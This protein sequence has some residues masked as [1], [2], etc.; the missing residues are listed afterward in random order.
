MWI[1]ARGARARTISTISGKRLH[2]AGLVVDEHDRHDRGSLVE[3]GGEGV[4]I[5]GAVRTGL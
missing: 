1:T 3:R 4:E 2:D 5:D